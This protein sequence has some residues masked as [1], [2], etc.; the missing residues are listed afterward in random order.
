MIVMTKSP[1][2][3]F[4]DSQWKPL[5]EANYANKLISNAVKPGSVL[6][7]GCGDGTLLSLLGERGIVGVGLDLSETAI[8]IARSRGM[9]CRVYDITE[10]LPFPDNNFD[11]VLLADVLEHLHYP[12]DILAEAARVS[13]GFVYVSTPNFVSFPAR[14]QA[15]RGKVP[16]NNTP[17]DGH[18]YWITD[19]V[20]SQFVHK[21]GL[22][23]DEVWDNT[24]WQNHIFFGP[25]IRRLARLNPSLFTLSFIRRYKVL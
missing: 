17:R 23:V 8:S 20:L 16:E 25:I 15:L 4:Q 2:A 3:K 10:P 11:S 12:G 22:V 6:D 24:F 9:D 13:R 19:A 14:L 7:L 5:V 21:S 18:V 1:E